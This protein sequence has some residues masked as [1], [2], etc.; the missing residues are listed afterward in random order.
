[1]PSDETAAES[2]QA[3]NRPVAQESAKMDDH[4][5]VVLP[6]KNETLVLGDGVAEGLAESIFRI[7]DEKRDG[8]DEPQIT[9]ADV[10]P[11][12]VQY[13]LLTAMLSIGDSYDSATEAPDGVNEALGHMKVA[14]KLLNNP[15]MPLGDAKEEVGFHV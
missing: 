1:M 14:T 11:S 12:Q 5:E 10:R 13:Q 7:L 4:V 15:E 3:I 6:G 2:G 9:R 8:L